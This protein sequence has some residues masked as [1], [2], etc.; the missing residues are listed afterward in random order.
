M[1]ISDE[2]GNLLEQA[3]NAARFSTRRVQRSHCLLDFCF[4]AQHLKYDPFDIQFAEQ[5]VDEVRAA[6]FPPSPV[7]L[8]LQ[9]RLSQLLLT[10]VSYL[11]VCAEADQ[12]RE[13]R[14]N[15][16]GA[17]DNIDVQ[18]NGTPPETLP[19]TLRLLRTFF[20]HSGFNLALNLATLSTLVCFREV[21][22]CNEGYP[23]LI[24]L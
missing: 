15:K 3:V 24:R 12:Q 16:H 7:L 10:C 11:A 9:V 2:N 5:K 8:S 14:L 21:H 4:V 1:T 23:M 19:I 13:H 18:P 20:M 17:S 22:L 6:S